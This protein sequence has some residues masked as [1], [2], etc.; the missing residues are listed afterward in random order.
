MDYRKLHLGKNGLPSWDGTMP[1]IIEVGDTGQN[2]KAKEL[3]KAVVDSMKLPDNLRTL[4]SEKYPDD[5]LIDGRIGF[6]MSDL[7]LSGLMERPHRGIYRV[8]QLGRDLFAEFGVNLNSKV[9]HK[10]EQYQTYQKERAERN[11]A[12]KVITSLASTDDADE[13]EA[14]QQFTLAA[15]IK[16]SIEQY[17]ADIADELLNRIRSSDPAFFERLVVK[18]LS[19]MGYQGA[20]GSSTVTPIAHDGGID[21]IINQDPLGTRTVYLQAKRYQAGNVVQRQA[22]EGFFGALSR[23]RADRGVFITTSSFSKSAIQTAKQFSIVLINGVQLTDLM[24]RYHVGV[25]TRE[26]MELVSIDEEY[27]EDE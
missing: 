21:G 18:L 6:A 16:S 26:Q 1:A 5:S 12:R 10:Q 27:F 20:E 2:W 25:Q 4:Y 3:T 22:I 13:D 23:I 15:Q 11:A 7:A 8:T 24:L 9:T 17:N 14:P 19:K